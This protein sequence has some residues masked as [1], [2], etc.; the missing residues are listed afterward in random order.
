MGQSR[1]CGL[2]EQI[3]GAF[4]LIMGMTGA[5]ALLLLVT[6]VSSVSAVTG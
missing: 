4:G 6:L 3:G 2:V 5:C 1:V